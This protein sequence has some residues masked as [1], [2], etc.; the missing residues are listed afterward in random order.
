MAKTLSAEQIAARKA[1]F[2]SK[3]A[4]RAAAKIEQTQVDAA[5]AVEHAMSGNERSELK[6]Q[7]D[8]DV[9]ESPPSKRAAKDMENQERRGAQ[10]RHTAQ[11][12]VKKNKKDKK[13]K[14]DKKKKFEKK[15]TS[16]AGNAS[17]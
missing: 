13:V 1:K 15:R 9:A 7:Q 2:A 17:I 12:K 11:R 4:R 14:K 8:G 16:L 6:R 5:A 10:R 3:K